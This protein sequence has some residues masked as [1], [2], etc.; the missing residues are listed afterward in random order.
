MFRLPGLDVHNL[1]LP[2]IGFH[3]LWVSILEFGLL[4]LEGQNTI[5][6]RWHQPKGKLSILKASAFRELT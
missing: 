5:S 3:C 6:S 4:P 2:V 1:S